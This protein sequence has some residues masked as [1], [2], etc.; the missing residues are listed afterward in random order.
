VQVEAVDELGIKSLETAFQEK[1]QA[2]RS[3]NRIFRSL[4][5]DKTAKEPR[6][7]NS[8]EPVMSHQRNS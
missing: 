5:S 6:T 1:L 2:L 7:R 8:K 3:R 4:F